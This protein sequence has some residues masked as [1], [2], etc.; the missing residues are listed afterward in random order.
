[1][2]SIEKQINLPQ[3]EILNMYST[4]RTTFIEFLK[5]NPQK[6]KGKQY[7]VYLHKSVRA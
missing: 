7:V 3:A 6:Q 5:I 4:N 2:I 1:M